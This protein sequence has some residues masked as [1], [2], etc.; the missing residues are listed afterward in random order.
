MNGDGGDIDAE[1]KER[2]LMDGNQWSQQWE[3]EEGSRAIESD[4]TPEQR[5]HEQKKKREKVQ[6]PETH[7]FN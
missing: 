5:Y 1:R 2:V 6:G 3:E 4:A 7:Q